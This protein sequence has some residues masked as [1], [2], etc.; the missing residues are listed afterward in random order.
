MSFIKYLYW[1]TEICIEIC[2]M[3]GLF[4][5]IV[6]EHRKSWHGFGFCAHAQG[7]KSFGFATNSWFSINDF[8][9]WDRNKFRLS[10]KTY[11]AWYAEMWC[12]DT[13]VHR[14]VLEMFLRWAFRVRVG[15]IVYDSR[16][17]ATVVTLWLVSKLSWHIVWRIW[18]RY[19][20]LRC[21]LKSRIL[22]SSGIYQ[23][24]ICAEWVH[25]ISWF[26]VFRFRFRWS[27][28]SS[29]KANN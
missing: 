18:L 20:E 5:H 1:T 27:W 4:L 19:E 14:F 9:V 26:A 6:A 12:L 22:M 2:L 17:C 15:G 28:R 7:A 23:E 24:W 21:E 29:R 10:R 11:L 16:N 8:P 13:H 25:G 3:N